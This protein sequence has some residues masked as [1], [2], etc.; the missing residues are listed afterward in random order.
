MWYEY[1]PDRALDVS[2]EMSHQ[3]CRRLDRGLLAE[4]A[5]GISIEGSG[6]GSYQ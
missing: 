6:S 1:V 4:K 3:M 2:K 5:A